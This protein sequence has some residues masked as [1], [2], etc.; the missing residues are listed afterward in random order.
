MKAPMSRVLPTP[1]AKAKHSDGNSRSKSVTVGNSLRIAAS[2]A[3]RSTAFLG[4]TISVIRSRIS[5]E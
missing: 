5:S 2:A 4:G 1:V 3:V